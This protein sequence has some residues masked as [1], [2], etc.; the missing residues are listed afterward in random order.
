MENRKASKLKKRTS[1][2]S[3]AQLQFMA[4]SMPQKIF[5]ATPDGTVDYLSHQW[6]EYTG[7]PST[8]F[9]G[10]GWAKLLHRNELKEIAKLWQR[11]IKTGEPFLAEH[12][13]RRFDG[14]Y[15][16]HISQARAM[17]DKHRR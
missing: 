3:E 7:R 5:T 13:L 1:S 17:H 12:R 11:A 10:K 2:K 16:W 14:E 9:L 15:R 8:E 4:E 6:E